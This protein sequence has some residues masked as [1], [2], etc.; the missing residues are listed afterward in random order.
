MELIKNKHIN[1]FLNQPRVK[2]R[3]VILFSFMALMPCQ[4]IFI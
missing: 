3:K 1:Y 2:I 4:A